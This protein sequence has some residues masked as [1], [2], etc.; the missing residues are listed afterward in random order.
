MRL[1]ERSRRLGRIDRARNPA[2][3]NPHQ[4]TTALR[5]IGS[6][7]L[8]RLSRASSTSSAA[9]I[10]DQHMVS[11]AVDRTF[12]RRRHLDAAASV[13]PAVEH[14]KLE[15]A[16]V[17]LHEREHPPPSLRIRRPATERKKCLVPAG[18]ILS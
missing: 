17:A 8:P 16:A 13:Q 15:P 9:E 10:E 2:I 3:S 5:S 18:S 7:V 12:E 4:I 11:L 1:P 14:G 6:K